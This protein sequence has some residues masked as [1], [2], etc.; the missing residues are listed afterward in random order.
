MEDINP[1]SRIVKFKSDVQ[2]Y[3]LFFHSYLAIN[4]EWKMALLLQLEP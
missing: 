2:E 4:M 1:E 3:K